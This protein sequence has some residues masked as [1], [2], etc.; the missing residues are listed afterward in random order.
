MTLMIKFEEETKKMG[1]HSMQMDWQTNIVNFTRTVFWMPCEKQIGRKT[2]IRVKKIC[3]LN[4][5]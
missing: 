2:E 1:R 5:R 4:N 3:L